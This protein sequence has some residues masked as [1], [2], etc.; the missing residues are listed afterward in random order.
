VVRS[1][2][3]RTEKVF[4]RIHRNKLRYF[5]PVLMPKKYGQY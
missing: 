5:P 1:A 3:D 2:P 4:A